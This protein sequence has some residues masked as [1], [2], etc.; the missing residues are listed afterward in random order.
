MN[1]SSTLIVTLP[2]S[3][4]QSS[5]NSISS[6][7][8]KIQ[9]CNET[10]QYLVPI[11]GEFDEGIIYRDNGNDD[12]EEEEAS[13]DHHQL[14]VISVKNEFRDLMDVSRIQF[15]YSENQCTF[16]IMGMLCCYDVCI[17]MCVY[18]CVCD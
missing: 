7:D 10:G 5:F 8:R 15:I 4:V 2:T 17:Y 18:V 12:D 13:E 6:V 9:A 16:I 3:I 1:G 14:L 11:D